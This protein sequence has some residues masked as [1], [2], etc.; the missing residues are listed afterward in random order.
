MNNLAVLIKK[1]LLEQLRTKK[2]LTMIIVM[3]FAAIASPIIAKLTPEILKSV[4]MPGLTI[5]LPA[6]I[7]LDSIDQF[8]KNTAQIGLLVII[9]VV[10]GAICDEKSKKTLEIILTKPFSRNVFVFSKF[11]AYFIAISLVFIASAAI[12]YSY[13]GFIFSYFNMLDFILM[14][15]G[16]LIYILMIVSVTIFASTLVKNSIAAGGIGF[17]FYIIFSSILG[18][19]EPIKD[20]LP[21]VFLE[22]YKT[23]AQNGW[24][25]NYLIPSLIA[26]AIITTSVILSVVAFKNQEIE[27]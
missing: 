1:D 26:V 23:I 13:T 7:Y 20:Y 9:F 27:R 2:I 21:N 22:Q 8:V 12:F 19:F 17:L 11:C 16:I 3:L 18:L 6:P 5:N 25:D 4:S 14:S 10:A 24:S 15:I